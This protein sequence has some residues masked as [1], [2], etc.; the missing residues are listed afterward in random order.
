M[1]TTQPIQTS[2][3]LFN[4]AT[5][6]PDI[7]RLFYSY[8]HILP[9]QKSIGNIDGLKVRQWMDKHW[10]DKI[11]YTYA[12]KV[13]VPETKDFW[14]M[15]VC[16]ILNNRMIIFL[17]SSSIHL[18]YDPIL[19]IESTDL[20]KMF[21]PY[22][23]K[24]KITQEISMV[25][26][27]YDGLDT[28]NI[29]IRKPKLDINTHYNNELIHIHHTVIS[30]LKKNDKSGL[31]LFYGTPGTGKST[32][33]RYLLRSINKKVI[34]IPP[35]LASSLD[36]PSFTNFMIENKNTVFVIEDAEDLLVSRN[37]TRNA[38]LS[39]ILNLTDGILGECLGI[40]IIATFNTDL[41]NI[42][43]ALLRKGRLLTKYEF[44]KLSVEKSRSLLH[45]LGHYKYMVEQPMTLADI[46]NIQETGYEIKS[47]R[48]PIGFLANAS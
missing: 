10:S 17:D 7:N 34:F 3:T 30:C 19:E 48:T 38:S 5:D 11:L 14:S 46:Y 32:Y 20:L 28:I 8:F 9:N 41:I 23:Y 45:S 29:K 1:E 40:Q 2:T 31:H 36:N 22:L 27:G 37:G 42:D 35:G 15:R 21:L 26:K 25:I 16:Y 13:W 4:K 43:K 39:M 18:Y 44:G 24:R 47:D 6:F 12:S 33:I